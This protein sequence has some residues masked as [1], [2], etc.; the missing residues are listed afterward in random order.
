MNNNSNVCVAISAEVEN[1]STK[2][3]S[4]T[5]A[6][7]FQEVTFTSRCGKTKYTRNKVQ[8]VKRGRI[9]AGASDKWDYHPLEIPQVP[10]TGLGGCRM[11][12]VSY[13]LEFRVQPKGWGY[14]LVVDLPIK[15]GNVPL[16]S[17]I[18]NI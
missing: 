18:E 11:I 16:R 10:P 13:Q 5:K 7:L 1:L 6:K 14:A 17:S 15:I 4:C 12:D 8:E 2:E 9:D 3:M